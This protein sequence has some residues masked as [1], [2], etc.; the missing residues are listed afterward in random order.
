MRMHPSSVLRLLL[1]LLGA[2]AMVPVVGAA[3]AQSPS[4][5]F[6]VMTFNIRY[7][8]ARDSLDA[9]PNRAEGVARL[10][11]F[12]DPDLLGLQEAQRN[13][14]DDLQRL[15]PGYA[16]FGLPRNDGSRGDEYSTIFYRAERFDLLDQGTFWLSQTPTVPA[17]RGWDAQLPR[18]A[19]WGRFR[20]RAT[21][22]TILHVNTHFDHVG[23]TARAESARL[24]KRWLAENARGLPVFVTGDFN[25]D[26]ASEP[27][28][29]LLAAAPEPRL[30]D[31]RA[32]SAEPPYGPNSTWN[33]FKAI[34][35]ERRIDFV[36]VGNGARVLE[37]AVL[38]ET[39]DNGRFPSDH[40]PVVAEVASGRR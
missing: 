11:G 8:N 32:V 13:Q 2:L 29:I 4:Q 26:P 3:E 6:R 9:W 7:N 15:L 25:A 36:F 12:H 28:Q 1:V 23:V 20:D 35:P 17:S 19:T 39:L 5:S 21:G 38:S 16:W 34:E 24:L 14:I 22:D 31:A 37:Y 10:I 27:V 33:G 40:L 18:I 30:A